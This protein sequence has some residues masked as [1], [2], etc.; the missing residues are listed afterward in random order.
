[1][2]EGVLEGAMVVENEEVE[3]GRTNGGM[4]CTCISFSVDNDYSEYV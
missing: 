4:Y 2:V 1:M 3:Y